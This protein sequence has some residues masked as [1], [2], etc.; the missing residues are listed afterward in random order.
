M[1]ES[2]LADPESHVRDRI[3]EEGCQDEARG[4]GS[5]SRVRPKSEQ[6]KQSAHQVQSEHHA[7]EPDTDSLFDYA[8]AMRQISRSD[9]VK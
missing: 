9:P 6:D 2:T 7:D 8:E 3:L 4:S 1:S 5:L